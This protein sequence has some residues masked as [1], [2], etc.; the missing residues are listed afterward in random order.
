MLHI[1]EPREWGMRNPRSSLSKD[2]A[3]RSMFIELNTNQDERI[4]RESGFK[5]FPIVAPRW[6]T[7]GGDIYGSGPGFE[8]IGSIKQLQTEQLRKGQAIDFMSYP[9]V[10]IPGDL[11]GGELDNL[12]GGANYYTS[13]N[14]QKIQNLFDVNLN[15]QH[16]LEDIQD[17]RGRINRTFFVDLFQMMSMDTRQQPP[18]AREV[19]ERHEEKLLMLGP[20][21]ERLHDELL[22]PMVDNCFTHALEARLLP[23]PPQQIEGS[24]LKIEFISILAQ[25]Q[26]AVGLQALDRL[27]GT[28]GAV[29]QS[30]GDAS[31]WDKIDKDNLIDSYS[32][33]LAV[34]ANVIVADEK[35]AIIRAERVKQQQMA[36]M[37]QIAKP[38]KDLAQ[39]GQALGATQ[40]GGP[41]ASAAADAIRQNTGL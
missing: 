37:A 25:A 9:P 31:V 28:V 13:L 5:D 26:R 6:L 17:V 33:R 11:K 10:M 12:P 30:S 16:L 38:A 7:R 24:D 36:Q 2:M 21:L 1:V 32:D 18:S 27:I 22:S 8:A 15:I 39:A 19:V 3:F 34:D 40:Q 4:L 14:G 41:V 23:P 35:V 29:A 20:V